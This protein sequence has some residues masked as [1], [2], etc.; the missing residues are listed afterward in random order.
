MTLLW[1]LAFA[2]LGSVGAVAG[3]ATV[4]LVPEKMRATLIPYL[5][6]YATGAL[7]GAALLGLLPHAI[8]HQPAE[9]MLA[10]VL[11]GLCL[12]F[13]LERIVIW[14]HCHVVGHCDVHKTSGYMILVGDALHNFVDGV[15]LA[16]TFLSSVPLGI[17]AGLAVIAHELPQE[18]GDFA[19]L[20]D[21]GLKRKQAFLLNL[22]SSVPTLPGA[23]L[24]Y[25]ALSQTVGSV[26]YVLAIAAA[27]FLYIGLADLVP[28]LQGRIGPETGWRQFLLM[29]TGV[30]TILLVQRLHG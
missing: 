24:G 1:I 25:F 18:V 11:A 7:L 19:I 2:V 29:L 17:A 23:L 3:A 10:T 8:E 26:P 12:F 28:G 9:A 21:S 27:S 15:M 22:L 14:R 16:A 20:L 13:V 30:G 6:S 4:L 5:V